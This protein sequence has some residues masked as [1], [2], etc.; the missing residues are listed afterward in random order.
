MPRATEKKRQVEVAKKAPVKSTPKKSATFTKAT[1][2]QPAKPAAKVKTEKT[3]PIT[4]IDD[5]QETVESG[6]SVKVHKSTLIFA[7]LIILLGILLYLGRGLIV[8]AVVNGQPISRVAVVQETEK[9]SGK[10]V[11]ASLIRNT[12][13]E[14]EASKKNVTVSDKE[15]NDQIKT[16]EDNLSKQGQKL[17]QMLTMEGM[18]KDDLRKIIRLDILVTKLVGK[19]IKISD[20]DI[21]NY[22]ASNKDVLPK[23]KSDKELKQFAKEQL[24][25]A[26]LPQKAQA[27]FAEL[28]KKAKIV[29][30]VDY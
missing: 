13:V 22:I 14:Q 11:M 25:K 10:Q 17:D 20:K 16:I 3:T 24:Q 29:K 1:T 2:R 15:I 9:A 19:D 30:F 6:R 26:Q 12:L 8:A 7:A 18:T 27:W 5:S 28:E 21:N 23:G 4:P